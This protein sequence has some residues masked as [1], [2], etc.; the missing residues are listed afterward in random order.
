VS[1]Y[2]ALG[3]AAKSGLAL[4]VSTTAPIGSLGGN[5]ESAG[6]PHRVRTLPPIRVEDRVQGLGCAVL[7]PTW[8]EG[9]AVRRSEHRVDHV[10]LVVRKENLDDAVSRFSALFAIQMEGP[11][12]SAGLTI[13]INWDAG[14]ELLSPEDETADNAPARFL[15]DRG[16]GLFRLIFGVDDLDAARQRAAS[17]GVRTR[18]INAFDLNPEW[19]E[20][21]ER[22]DEALLDDPIFGSLVALVSWTKR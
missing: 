2:R 22:M 21:Y 9:T 6:E 1:I 13:Y 4:E 16:E 12:R 5:T 8:N 3:S 19:A 7:L 11:F 17:S 20:R 15:R 10:A 14:L 18:D